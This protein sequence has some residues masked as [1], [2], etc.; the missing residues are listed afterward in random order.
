VLAVVVWSVF[1]A[2]P[3]LGLVAGGLAGLDPWLAHFLPFW[4]SA[5]GLVPWLG[6][7]DGLGTWWPSA[8]GQ[9]L[10]RDSNVGF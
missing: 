9:L 4:W 2:C 10:V 3:L 1:W 6:Y 5:I 7:M 8:E